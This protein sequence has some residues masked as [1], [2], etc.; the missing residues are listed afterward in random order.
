MIENQLLHFQVNVY[1]FVSSWDINF[2]SL[3]ETDV[4]FFNH[5]KTTSGQKINPNIPSGV[6]GKK[7]IRFWLHDSDND[8]K[9]RE[10]SDRV[11]H[12]ICHAVLYDKYDTKDGIWVKGVHEE[13]ERF[14]IKFWYWRKFFWRRF[15]LSVIDIRKLL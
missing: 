7:E 15:Q 5:V 14:I 9:N 12:E 11:Q 1:D 10:N 4:S 3:E 6:T 13:S 2:Y 8:F